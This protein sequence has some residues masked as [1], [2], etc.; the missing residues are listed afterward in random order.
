MFADE[1][2]PSPELVQTPESASHI[3]IDFK[4]KIAKDVYESL[5]PKEKKEIDDRREAERKQQYR[6]IAD[7]KDIRERDKKLTLHQQ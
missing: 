4:L 5:S 2:D 6:S 7:I 3:P 1:E